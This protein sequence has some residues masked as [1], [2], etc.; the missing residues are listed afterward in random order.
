MLAWDL[1]I[2]GHRWPEG[3]DH[4]HPESLS[5]YAKYA[6]SLKDAADKGQELLSQATRSAGGFADDED[7]LVNGILQCA[8]KYSD[9]L[10]SLT[11]ARCFVK[12][13]EN[14][15]ECLVFVPILTKKWRPFARAIHFLDF[16]SLDTEVLTEMDHLL[17]K[18]EVFEMMCILME[19]DI[20]KD[21]IFSSMNGRGQ[22]FKTNFV[23]GVEENLKTFDQSLV[24]E[25]EA[26]LKTYTPVFKAAATWTMEGVAWAFQGDDTKRELEKFN[27][28]LDNM[29][30]FLKSFTSFANHKSSQKDMSGLTSKASE[31]VETA[32][33][34][35]GLGCE[36][37][38]SLMCSG[39]FLETEQD[40]DIQAVV[41]Y[42][43]ENYDVAVTRLPAKLSSMVA[44]EVQKGGRKREDMGATPSDGAPSAAASSKKDKKT[45]KD[46]D[47]K[48]QKKD[49]DKKDKEK[50]NKEKKGKK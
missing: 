38:A 13:L 47:D 11:N 45:K 4:D 14:P 46:K 25:V 36:V 37:A 18:A 35:I 26:F 34:I 12:V 24:R 19:E 41:K 50:S 8:V 3:K 43:N 21:P 2:S 40:N 6:I 15:E 5:L 27:S 31:A 23:K 10:L 30:S 49:K 32:K 42:V 22:A 16:D 29:K 44:D 48:K 17:N 1:L 20:S 9:Y 7:K 33:K 28:N 39:Y